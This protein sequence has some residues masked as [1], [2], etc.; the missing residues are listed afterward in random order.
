MA[1]TVKDKDLNSRSSRRPLKARR[2]PYWRSIDRGFHIGY[3]KHKDGGG[4]WIA[5]ARLED[6][7]YKFQ[8]IGKAD[9]IQDADGVA[10]MDFSQA[11]AEA[12]SWYE[13]LKKMEKGV[14]VI[15]YTVKDAMDDYLDYLEMNTKS[16]KQSKYTIEAHILPVFG[17]KKVSDLTADEIKRWFK[18]ITVTQPRKR[19]RVGGISYKDEE[20]T[21]EYMR[22][23]KSSANRILT[24]LKAGLN[25]A[26]ENRK[27]QSDDAWRIVKPYRNVDH[28]KERFLTLNECVR[29]INACDPEFRKLVKAALYTGCRYGELTRMV[30]SDYNPD[31]ATITIAKS[32]TYKKRN[33]RLD[34]QG[35]SFLDQEIIGK[36]GADLIFT[37]SESTGQVQWGKSHQT[38][39]MKNACQ[40]AKI[41]PAIGFNILRHT[42]ASQLVSAGVSMS[43][44][45]ELLGNS[46]RICEKHYA[47]FKP[48]YISDIVNKH[49]PTL[50]VPDEETNVVAI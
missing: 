24:V 8:Q 39:R 28:A 44:I 50:D 41:T 30:V 2:E 27:V 32:K 4:S 16:A 20:N 43:V 35:R 9:D 11:Q 3:R 48:D 17:H 40:I 38:R 49:F 22:R 25:K 1:R 10:V 15:D 13:Q 31:T 23:R 19:S 6:K 45:A 14:G 37:K 42:Y 21:E 26:V 34:V 29:L 36:L 12:R 7:S 5:R 33:I 47:R 46:V 18:D